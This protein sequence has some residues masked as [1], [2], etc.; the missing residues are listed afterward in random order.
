VR[1]SGE[2]VRINVH[3]VD[4]STGFDIWAEDFKGETKSIFP[5]G[6]DRAEDAQAS[7]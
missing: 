6:A 3:L 2:Q 5:A 1:K 4:S 7:I